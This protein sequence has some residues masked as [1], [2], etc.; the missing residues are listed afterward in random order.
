MMSCTARARRTESSDGVVTAS[1]IGVGVQAVAVV[2]G[3]DQC[4]QRRAYIVE[5]H[6]LG[7]QGTPGRLNV[8]LELLASARLLPYLNRA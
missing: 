2:I 1:S 6:F 7:V 5:I 3:G 8:V 4:L